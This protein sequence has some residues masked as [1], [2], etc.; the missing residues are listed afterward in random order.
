MAVR[1]PL[2]ARSSKAKIDKIALMGDFDHFSQDLE[3]WAEANLLAR[4][5]RLREYQCF[6]IPAS[7]QAKT[8]AFPT[9]FSICLAWDVAE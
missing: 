6:R 9:L 8:G 2:L 5:H 1:L 7:M 4:K 3:I